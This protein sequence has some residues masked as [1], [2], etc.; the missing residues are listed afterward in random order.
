MTVYLYSMSIAISGENSILE[1]K[2]IG[3]KTKNAHS[4]ILTEQWGGFHIL[5]RLIIVSGSLN[6]TIYINWFLNF[7]VA[8][9][10]QHVSETRKQYQEEQ[11]IKYGLMNT[12]NF[13]C[14]FSFSNK[15]LEHKK[16]MKFMATYQIHP[17]E[18]GYVGSIRLQ[19]LQTKNRE[20]CG[21]L[22]AS[23]GAGN[24]YP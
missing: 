19:M 17:P 20:T 7:R 9:R 11:A 8:D 16:K 5:N 13:D 2:C 4:G 10:G 1:D 24:H 3:I 14:T 15:K 23:A 6:N 12:E 22:R 18:R 21:K